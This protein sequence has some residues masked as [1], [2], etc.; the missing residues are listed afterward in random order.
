LVRLILALAREGVACVVIN[1]WI[2]CVHGDWAG[3]STDWYSRRLVSGLLLL[4]LLLLWRDV[5]IIT[6]L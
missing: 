4:L 5:G 3:N 6:L 2:P 1:D